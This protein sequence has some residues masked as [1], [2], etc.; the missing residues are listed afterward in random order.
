M[1]L[2]A[3][4][5]GR[6]PGNVH[7]RIPRLPRSRLFS[8]K[9]RHS[10][11]LL[12]GVRAV[13][14][15]GKRV[16]ITFD[17]SLTNASD[18]ESCIKA[19]SPSRIRSTRVPP[20]PFPELS[21]L[22]LSDHP[23]AQLVLSALT[24]CLTVYGKLPLSAINIL[25]CFT[26][27]PIYRRAAR[28][29]IREHK[30]SVDAL[31]AL[32]H[33][34]AQLQKN[35]SAVALMSLILSVGDLL[36]HK[37][38]EEVE[39]VLT[40][41]LA[42]EKDEAW[43]E[44][45]GERI[46]LPVTEIR[47]GDKVIVYPGEVIPV[48][49]EVIHGASSVDQRSLTG[50][51]LPALKAEHDK[52]YAGT[53]ALE[54]VL[55]VS[56]QKVGH[57]TSVAR[58]LKVVRE[59]VQYTTAIEDY[60]R[61]FGDRLV[62]PTLGIGAAVSLAARDLSRFTSMIIVDLGT[63]MRVSAPTVFVS[64]MIAA[65]RSGVLIKG[66]ASLEKMNQADVIVFDKTGTLTL[67]EPSIRKV[68]SLHDGLSEDGIVRLAAAAESGF[69]HPVALAILKEAEE[70]GLDIP[71]A[72][73][74]TYH[75]GYGVECQI[76]DEHTLLGCDRFLSMNQIDVSIAS[77][78]ACSCHDAGHSIA[79]LAV[80][81]RL[82][83]LLSY[84]DTVRREAIDVVQALRS[85]GVKRLI[86]LTGDHDRIAAATCKQLGL[87]EF[88]AEALPEQKAAY[89]TRLQREGHTVVAVGDGINDSPAL[90]VADVGIT[91]RSGV[92][93]TR[94]SADVILMEENLWKI[95][96]AFHFASNAMRL[97]EQNRRI[98]YV[99]NGGVF[100]SAALGVLSPAIASAISDGASVLAT[101]NSLK[102]LVRLQS[103]G[104]VSRDRRVRRSKIRS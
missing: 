102:P 6:Y 60:A 40:G 21:L 73:G 29:L 53:V 32:A 7:V 8:H 101:V 41:L 85:H 69:S 82:V 34:I 93:L 83:G 72:T 18:I 37:T 77:K 20:R 55:E 103:G 95:V 75:I 35:Y 36:R 24:L 43:I 30:L 59:G 15:L 61:R 87:D 45:G 28:A 64:E 62:L 12:D 99:I 92:E 25:L 11:S 63:G 14:I 71:D 74:A 48:D 94:Q 65:A 3:S 23:R 27:L 54:G 46:R 19:L 98:L 67:G 88:V 52:V 81:G 44:R 38:S 47:A 33:I 9:L 4:V 39:R 96:E 90:T 80:N 49:G 1:T 10:L 16:R 79:F 84:A 51:S 26:S 97:I 91:V 50:E 17:D 70:R 56:A 2:D 100:V 57:D 42:F 89:I 68:I 78:E 5:I 76:D 66:G 22:D 31:D 58:I 104:S 86:M 13:E